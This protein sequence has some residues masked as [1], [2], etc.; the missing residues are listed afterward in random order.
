MAK[1]KHDELLVKKNKELTAH[2]LSANKALKHQGHLLDEA[3]GLHKNALETLQ[4]ITDK[5]KATKRAKKTL[6]NSEKR[7]HFLLKSTTTITYTCEAKA[8]FGATF[9]SENVNELTGYTPQDYISDPN[10]WASNIHPDDKEK[11]FNGLTT[12]FEEGTHKHNYR[13]KYKNGTYHWMS[14]TLKLI[15]DAQEKPIEIV[16]NWIDISHIKEAEEKIFEANRKLSLAVRT[17]GVGIWDWDI[18]NNELI[19]DNQMYTIYGR[20]PETF[21]NVYESWQQGLH[22]DDRERCNREIKEAIQGNK[23]FNTEYRVIWPDSSIHYLRAIAIVEFDADGNPLRMIGTNWD[24][25]E[26]KQKKHRLRL[27]LKEVSDYKYAL[28]ESSIVAITDQNGIIKSVNDNFCKISKYSRE[29]LVGQ[30]PKIISSGL[31]TQELL[32]DLNTTIANGKPWRGEMKNRTKDGD[33]YWVDSSIIPF[34]NEKGKPFQYMVIRN[35]I[36]EQKLLETEVKQFNIE[37]EQKVKVRTEELTARENQLTTIF[38]TVA[39]VIFALDVEKDGHYRFNSVNPA[40]LKITQLDY[41]MVVGK[42][43][44]HVI[45]KKLLS[46]VDEK[47][48]EAI[49]TKRIVRWEEVSDYP[50]RLT[51]EVSIAPIFDETGNCIKLIGSVHD[52][53][54]RKKAEEESEKS[55]QLYKTLLDKMSDGFIVDDMVGKVIFANEKFL[56][57]FG[58]VEADVDNLILENYVAPEYCEMLLDRH[59]LRVAGEEVPDIFEYEGIRKDG[60][61][62]WVEVRVAQVIENGTIKGTQSLIRDITALKKAEARLQKSE[63]RFRDLFENAPESILVLDLMSLKFTKANKNTV[64][65]F[66][67]SIEE[68][69]EKGPADIS[70]EFQLDGSLSE[71]KAMRYI[72]KAMQ[73]ERVSF[74][75]MH[76]DA[77]K[78]NILC[79]VHLALIP[80]D[81]RPQIYASIVDIHERNEIR[82]KLKEQYREIEKRSKELNIT[83]QQLKK[84]NSEL[85]RFVYSASHDLRSPLKSLIGLSDLIL[86]DIEMGNTVELEQM[87]MMKKSIIKLDD[88]IEDI[89][90]Y[91]RNARTEVAQEAIDFKEIIQDIENGHKHMDGAK[92]IKLKVDIRQDM[93][94]VSDKRRVN[95]V[96]NNLI[97]NAI[98]Y[99]DPSKEKPFVRVAIKCSRDKAMI[100]IKDNGIGIDTMD[101]E[102]IF[103]MFYR[104]T[105]TSKGSGLGLYIVKEALDKLN[106]TINVESELG[107]GTKFIV[108][109]PNQLTVLN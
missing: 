107:K 79:E 83:N 32:T 106:G 104:A 9:I 57:I 17:G 27:S 102:K 68:F 73:G 71:E 87:Y 60:K 81:E 97:S 55:K 5:L 65:L 101:K 6:F 29:E 84:T 40:F 10:F 7:L 88:F 105:K 58:L 42:K 108:T 45:P 86:D 18:V 48:K 76:C 30:D 50:R 49:R 77:N 100:H 34:L 99:K 1:N 109:L 91:S 52:L 98:K 64:K 92:G 11:V 38:N 96:L 14:D 12:L 62:I 13:W 44:T 2:L 59:T 8:P 16:G 33:I 80:G 51:G 46:L 25:T 93:N 19:W 36:T 95:V 82:E 4:K 23:E 70:P 43:I 90:Q 69:I 94:F 66:K 26:S 24:I 54:E 21:G 85:D 15:Y 103:E 47:C 61:R 39:D 75:W 22:P 78:K 35:D 53:T 63:H 41:D 74:E 72:E 20:T 67:Y 31:N 3:A 28:D 37:L 89:L 56:K